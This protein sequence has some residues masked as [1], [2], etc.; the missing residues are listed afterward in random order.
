[1]PHVPGVHHFSG[2]AAILVGLSL[3]ALVTPRQSI[4]AKTGLSAEEQAAI[5][6][7]SERFELAGL[8]LPNV[9]VSFHPTQENCH[10]KPGMFR[11][12]PAPHVD[13]CLPSIGDT[14]GRKT[15]LHE[16]SHAWAS[17]FLSDHERERFLEVRE[18]SVWADAETPWE[19]QGSEHAAEILSWALFDRALDLVTIPNADLNSVA[20]G[21]TILTGNA[22]PSR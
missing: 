17:Q 6:W 7:A 22:L 18:L 20:I 13:I 2:L 21:Y 11:D 4:S 1:M 14:A 15:L 5:S 9:T 10:G 3:T 19:W 12:Q 8:P 16:L